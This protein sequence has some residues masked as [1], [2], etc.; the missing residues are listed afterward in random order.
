MNVEFTMIGP[1]DR[2]EIKEMVDRIV[3]G[4]FSPS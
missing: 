2:N 3:G 1:R 4:S